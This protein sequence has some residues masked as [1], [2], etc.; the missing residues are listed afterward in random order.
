MSIIAKLKQR[1]TGGALTSADATL[2]ASILRRQRLLSRLS[3]IL[4]YLRVGLILAGFAYLLALPFPGEGR[5]KQGSF[6]GRGHYVS[7]NALQPGQVRLRATGDFRAGAQ[8]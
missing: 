2:R 1:L 7:E 4:P 6:L 8:G 3:A 5:G